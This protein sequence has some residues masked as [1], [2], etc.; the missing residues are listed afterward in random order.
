M[1]LRPFIDRLISFGVL[2]EPRNGY[3]V[4]WP[5]IFTPSEEQQAKTAETRAKALGTYAGAPGADMILPPAMFLK[6]ILGF[7]NEQVKEAGALLEGELN[8]E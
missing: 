7:T 1:I 4:E 8:Q 2:P 5:P 3:T 6:L